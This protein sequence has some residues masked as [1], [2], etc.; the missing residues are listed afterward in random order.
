MKI[1]ANIAV[2]THALER[3][4][5]LWEVARAMGISE[6][7]LSRML[8]DPLPEATQERIIDVIDTIAEG[9]ANDD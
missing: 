9:G 8:R 1:R 3:G 2:R 5:Y 7:K 6:Y 4:V